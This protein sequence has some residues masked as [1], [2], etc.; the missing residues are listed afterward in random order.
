MKVE[1]DP[2]YI[3][4]FIPSVISCIASLTTIIKIT[5]AKNDMKKLF[6]QLSLILAFIDIVQCVSW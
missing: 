3:W 5:T 4:F 6:H 2:A 1:G